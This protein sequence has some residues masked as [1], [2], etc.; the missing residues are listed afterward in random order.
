M[1]IVTT[2]VYV[3]Y[4]AIE[5]LNL[6]QDSYTISQT[7]NSPCLVGGDF[8]VILS[9]EEK[10]GGLLVYPGEYMDFLFCINSCDLVDI[11]FNGSPFTWW[12]GRADSECIFKKLD[13]W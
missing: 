11:N 2:I 9:D 4:D 1:S 5:I 8:N 7:N 13:N 3:K 6:W 12:N 10:I